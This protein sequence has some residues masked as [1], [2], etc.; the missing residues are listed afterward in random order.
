MLAYTAT[1]EGC[2]P[3]AVLLAVRG[4]FYGSL[5]SFF[6]KSSFVSNRLEQGLR[7]T[8]FCDHQLLRNDLVTTKLMYGSCFESPNPNPLDFFLNMHDKFLYL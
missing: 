7:V 5:I 2:H 3:Q 1:G 4:S 8:S 6:L